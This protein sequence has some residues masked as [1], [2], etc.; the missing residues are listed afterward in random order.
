MTISKLTLILLPCLLDCIHLNG[1]S[2]SVYNGV[3]FEQGTR[4]RLDSVTITNRNL[5]ASVL[6]DSWGV[7]SILAATG[8][9][10]D[11][12]RKNYE[13]KTIIA[14]DSMAKVVF[15]KPFMGLKEVI[16]VGN[17][18][19]RELLET[20]RIFKSKGVFY[21]G[22]PHY[23]YLFLKPM[24]FIYENFKSEVKSARKFRKFA[25]AELDYHDTSIRFSEAIIRKHTAIGDKDIADFKLKYWPEA[26]DIKSWSDYELISYIKKCYAD[27]IKDRN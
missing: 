25:K 17:S 12:L 24:T 27:F 4:T 26:E 18:V 9:T 6:S 10:L 7:F 1:Q 2:N 23:Y 5:K 13:I 22:T 21:T 15:L 20:Q 11:L 16:I 14:S 3:I 8:D 19:K